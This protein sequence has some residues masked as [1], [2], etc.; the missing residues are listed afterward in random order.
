M[1]HKIHFWPG[2]CPGLRF[3]AEYLRRSPKPPSQI[4]KNILFPHLSL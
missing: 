1:P 4:E 3:E 2:L